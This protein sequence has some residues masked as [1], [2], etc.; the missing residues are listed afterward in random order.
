MPL[1]DHSTARNLTTV[2][3]GPTAPRPSVTHRAAVTPG[4]AIGRGCQVR[5]WNDLLLQPLAI[6]SCA[7]LPSAPM[8]GIAR[9]EA[10][11]AFWARTYLTQP[12]APWYRLTVELWESSLRITKA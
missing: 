10:R 7:G 5:C 4:M 6:T 2:T 8:P 1:S 11:H 12:D 9:A 3:T